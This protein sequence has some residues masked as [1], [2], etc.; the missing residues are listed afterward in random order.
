MLERVLFCC[1]MAVR[2]AAR[3]NIYMQRKKMNIIMH[4]RESSSHVQQS[5]F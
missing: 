4:V 1:I 3:A 5:S 2:E